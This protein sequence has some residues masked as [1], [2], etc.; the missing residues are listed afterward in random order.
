ML[1]RRQQ[2]Q[3]REV[4]E[5]HSWGSWRARLAEALTFFWG[6]ERSPEARSPRPLDAPPSGAARFAGAP[7]SLDV[8]DA[9]LAEVVRGLTAE[10][11]LSVVAP[12]SFRGTVTA[13]L[14]DVP[15]DQALDLVLAGNGW[16]FRREG[17]VLRIH[18]RGEP[19][20]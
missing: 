8:K 13:S 16:A 4:P 9:D 3:Y 20:P 5:G 2:V 1:S 15:W 6:D 7:V 14:R 17:N 18:R 10:R 19:D 12:P 11:G